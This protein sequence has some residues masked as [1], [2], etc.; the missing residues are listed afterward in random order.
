MDM[1]EWINYVS[2]EDSPEEHVPCEAWKTKITFTKAIRNALVG[3]DQY[4][5]EVQK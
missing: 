4:H 5:K 3:G 1:L 2:S